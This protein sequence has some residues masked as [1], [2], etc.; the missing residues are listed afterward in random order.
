MKSINFVLEKY[1]QEKPKYTQTTHRNAR[2]SCFDR[3]GGMEENSYT[4][5]KTGKKATIV[6]VGDMLCEEKLYKSHVTKRGF[7]FRDIF[8]FVR[9]IFMAADLTIGNL[10]TMVCTNAPYTGEQ[11][12]IDGKYHCNAPVEFLDAIHDAGVD[13]LMLS[14]NHNLDCGVEG[15]IETLWHIDDHGMMHTGLFAP[16]DASRYALVEVNGIKLALLSYSTWFNR[17]QTRLTSLGQEKIINEY[18]PEKVAADISAAKSAGAEFILVY[19]HW[20]IDAEYSSVPSDTMKKMAQQVADF[21][22]DYI[23]GSHTHSIQPSDVLT[24]HDGRIVPVAW[25]MGNF[26]TSEL[27]S[28]SRSTGILQIELTRQDGKVR[29]T[30]ETFVPCYI[31]DSAYGLSY[32]VLPECSITGE[33]KQTMQMK[34]AIQKVKGI[35]TKNGNMTGEW[36]LTKKNICAALGLPAPAADEVYTKLEYAQ[37]AGQGCV[38]L[39]RTRAFDPYIYTSPEECERLADLAMSKGAKLLLTNRQIKDYPCLVVPEPFEA[40]Q[41]IIAA[42]RRKFTGHVVGITGSIGKTSTTG[43]VSAVLSSKY[44]TF[45]NLHNA[46][47]AIFAA[48]LIQRL[49]PE[50]GAYVQEIMETPPYGLAGM[51]AKMVQPEVAIVTVVGTSHMKA[52]GSQERIRETCLSVAEGLREDGTLILNG[53]DPFQKNPGCKQKVLYYAIDNQDADYR[54]EN[55]SGGENGME[56]DVV[57]GGQRVPVKIACYGL[58]NVMDALAAFAAGKCIG[59]TDAEVVRGLA[60][61]RTMGIRQNVVKYG[62]Q[63]M[64]L[65]CYNAAAESMQSSF[66]SFAMIPVK[67]GGRRIAVLGDI[68][69]TGEK[70]EEIHA[71]V[72]RMLAVS[73]VDIAVCYGDSA[74]I[75]ADMAKSLCGKEIVWSNDFDTVKNWLAQNVT[76]NDVL[77]FKGSRGMALERF[78]DALTG[79]WFYE[80]DEDLIAG[81]HL[82]TVNNLTY[83]V[84]ADH[85]TL[86]SKDAS[87]PDVVIDAYVDGKPVT[88]IGENVFPRGKSYT[89]SVTFPDTLRNI[90]YCAFYKT[91]KLKTVSTPPS[92][93]IIDNS[94]FSTC[95]NL[96]TVEIAEGCT[97]LGYR[98]FGNCK[99][100]EKIIIPATVR[101]IGGECFINCAKLT[102]YGIAESYAEQYALT[103]N[104]PFKFYEKE[105]MHDEEE[106]H[107]E[108]WL[109]IDKI[110][111]KQNEDNTVTLTVSIANSEGAHDNLWYTV[112]SEYSYAICDEKCDAI[113]VTLLIAAM[114][115][116]YDSIRCRYPISRK[117][118]YS[119]TYHVIPQLYRA[120]GTI[121]PSRIRIDAPLSDT[122]YHGKMIAAGMSR[123]VDSFATMSEYGPSFELK[124]YRINTFTYFQ[125]GAHHGWDATVGRG[126]ESKEELYI[127]Q[128]EG[129]RAFCKKYGYP[130]IVVESNIDN[131]LLNR[132]LFKEW[133]FDR[134]HTCRNLAIAML[135]QKGISRYYYSS[136]YLLKDFRLGLDIDNA[137]YERWLIPLLSTESIEFYQSN[138]DWT[139]MDKVEK[140]SNFEPC[141]NYLQ[142]CL[143]KTG[144]CGRCAKCKRTLME[145]DALGDGVLER[146]RNSFDVERYRAE[147]RAK[148]FGNIMI[149]KAKP[150]AEAH[151][152][153]EILVCA[154]K[155]HPELLE[156]LTTEKQRGIHSVRLIY[157]GVN[158]RDLPSL[159]SDILFVAQKGDVFTYFGEYPGWVCILTNNGQRAFIVKKFVELL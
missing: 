32:P 70:D 156:S 104:I 72:G 80:M 5:G 100:L 83:R 15:V 127:H 64:F 84:Y 108:K 39:V 139:R 37:D 77:L 38:A 59:M 76:V 48:K 49:T 67:D 132:S 85:A 136:A 26:V 22:A 158:V 154:A 90:R 75:I 65:D 23:I 63:T 41:T 55:I 152:L 148:W 7:D 27:M 134:T 157:N 155:H 144:N 130:L 99:N 129:S 52:L 8:T 29:V 97:H 25:S 61:F 119:L 31:P 118:Y 149:D 125:A 106:V 103:H 159:Q 50:Y 87:A 46:N 69:E 114:K 20:G 74:A 138:Q 82:K 96:R 54:A 53:D 81:S 142:V 43:M 33:G 110:D 109:L 147:D 78:A 115:Y 73:S 19:M 150:G 18:R 56:F 112:A 137:Y 4:D 153:D 2:I 66:N 12:K 133:S 123:G 1:E 93:R 16:E 24:A 126:V 35:F 91:N 105:K 146:F 95:E 107:D 60:S 62:G 145:L 124:D 13:F 94:A 9:P 122:V 28:V 51:I 11:Y 6:C 120:T 30:G 14:N 79:T 47:S 45:S 101:E 21:G 44:K 131:V 102:I 3:N 34:E 141:Y 57:Y 116:G 40:F 92:I 68:K 143:T 88:G 121:H 113:V 89:A 98:A 17:N 117:L 128:M 151:Y 135:L 71:S 10:E 58:H 111:K 42:I 86:V 36:I 140:I